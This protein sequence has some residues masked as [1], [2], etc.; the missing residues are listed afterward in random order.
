MRRN[1]KYLLPSFLSSDKCQL[2]SSTVFVVFLKFE[3]IC[4]I[5]EVDHDFYEPKAPGKV[6]RGWNCLNRFG[7]SFSIGGVVAFKS[8]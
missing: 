5:V 3:K 6:L 2:F 7:G 4:Q 8:K 1:A